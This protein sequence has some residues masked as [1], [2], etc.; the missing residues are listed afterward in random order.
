MGH[1][2]ACGEELMEVVESETD[3]KYSDAT[4][5]ECPDCGGILGVTE[6]GV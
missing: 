4:V 6:I 1:C 5:W 2:I 3:A